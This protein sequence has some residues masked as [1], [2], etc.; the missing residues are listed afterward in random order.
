MLSKLQIG[1]ICVCPA[2]LGHAKICS[3]VKKKVYRWHGY[4]DTTLCRSGEELPPDSSA[5]LSY[6]EH[7]SIFQLVVFMANNISSL[8]CCSVLLFST[9]L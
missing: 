8:Q 1:Y 4:A 7:F 9:L 2:S 5:P 6:M 3:A